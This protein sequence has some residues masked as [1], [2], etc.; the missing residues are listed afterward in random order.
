MRLFIGTRAIIHIAICRRRVSSKSVAHL[1]FPIILKCLK[2][3]THYSRIILNQK[4]HL[5]FPNYSGIICQ[6]LDN[7][8]AQAYGI[9]CG[10]FNTR[11]WK[12]V[13]MWSQ[14]ELLTYSRR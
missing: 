5:L 8:H 7:T 12:Q 14:Q 10:G 9:L 4:I 2:I 13:S 3:N 6:G 11:H 1:S